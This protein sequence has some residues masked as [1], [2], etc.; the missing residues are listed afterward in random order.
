VHQEVHVVGLPVEFARLGTNPGA[1]LVHELLAVGE[2]G[3]GKDEPTV[4]VTNTRWACKV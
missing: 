2:H 1:H 3:V 4:L